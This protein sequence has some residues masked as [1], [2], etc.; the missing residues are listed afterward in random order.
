MVGTALAFIIGL[1]ASHTALESARDG[2]FLSKIPGGRLPL[3]YIAI[4]LLSYGLSRAR[5]F[6]PIASRRTELTAWTLFGATGTLALAIAL[7][8]LGDVGLYALYIW[9]GIITA[10]ILVLFWTIVGDVF[11]ATQAKRLYGVI[12]LGSMVGAAIGSGIV[13]IIGDIVSPRSIV[14]A[15]A[16]GMASLAWLPRMLPGRAEAAQVPAT[17]VPALDPLLARVRASVQYAT[18]G[19][20]VFRLL[21]LVL[22]GSVAVTLTDF[23]FKSTMAQVV[24]KHEL[25][26]AFARTYLVLN[27]LSMV[28]Q[29][30]AVGVLLRRFSAP[31]MVAVLPLLLAGTGTVVAIT[32][33]LAAAM[34]AKGVDGALRH[35]LYR[36][37][38]EL[39]CVPLSDEARRRVKTAIEIIGQRGGQ[40]LASL[41]ILSVGFFTTDLRACVLVMAGTSALWAAL[42]IRLGP[43]YI[44]QFRDSLGRSAPVRPGG[45]MQLDVASLE[46]L[47][48][49]LDSESTD[50]VLAALSLLE[51]ERKHRLVPGL[52]LFHPREEVVVAALRL[53]AR[54][55]RP[56]SAHAFEHLVAHPS[57]RVRAE[58]YA[59]KVALDPGAPELV[60]ALDP[61]SDPEARAA[62]IT[63][64]VA[65]GGFDPAEGGALLA[66]EMAVAGPHTK[67]AVAE[68]IGWRAIDSLDHIVAT[69]AA[70]T[71]LQ[72][73]Q[74][75]I[76][77][78][79]SLAT[80]T[81]ANALVALLAE[82]TVQERARAALTQSPKVSFA[83][84]AAALADRSRAPSVRWA[85]PRALASVDPHAAATLLLEDLRTEPDG[86]VR[87]RILVT[88]G[89]ILERVPHLVLERARID[90]EI[91]DHVARAYRYLDRR[92]VLQAGARALPSRATDGHR[93]L[94]DLLSD[95]ER[96]A[97]GR[98]FRLLGL[99]FPQHDF[100]N[101]YRALESGERLHRARAVE[102]TSNLLAAPLR[103]AVVGLVDDLDDDGRLRFAEPYHELID[104]DYEGLVIR[105]LR[106]R[107]A[108]VRD[109]AAFHASEIGGDRLAAAVGEVAAQAVVSEDVARAAA[110]LGGVR[111]RRNS[112]LRMLPPESD[113]VG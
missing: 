53:F 111:S 71:D 2:L 58:A 43:Y 38:I 113:L 11:T 41:V 32:G 93:L 84:L 30:L 49:A 91:R 108:I 52:I 83:A 104:R 8:W 95:K 40:V 112:A 73:R 31:A 47:V 65:T 16:A 10:T 99:A 106:S 70:D 15:A 22:A 76:T 46:T 36:T 101:I 64:M 3:V 62:T 13:G 85:L 94:V 74:A 27:L 87:Y 42:A 88:L 69:L 20:Y 72:V 103:D 67:I 34:A 45:I 21:G 78:L 51:R 102:L 59:A 109:V 97:V 6:V 17:S 26:M 110:I 66:A 92:S 100:G 89:A 90:E 57:A 80:P 60:R 23:V 39:L 37:G 33:G 56:L 48:A 77:A 68:V 55:R 29:V 12:G 61:S 81:A 50:Q 24:P 82:E 18:R 25:T 5:R 98:I 28:V 75:A 19:P 107:S 1:V 14:F 79:G 63:A 35:G 86:M 105:L 96:N 7:P 54:K 9:A 44:D 4:A